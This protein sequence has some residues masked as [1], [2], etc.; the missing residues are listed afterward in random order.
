MRTLILGT[1]YVGKGAQGYGSRM[2]IL[3]AKLAMK[4]NPECDILIVDSASPENP[5][6]FLKPLIDGEGGERLGIYRF[7]DNIGHLNTTGRD[8]WGRALSKGINIAIKEGYDYI[9]YMDVDIIFVR[10]VAEI[11]EK[12]AR[13]GVKV[14]CPMDR[15]YCFLENGLMFMSVPYLRDTKFVER[16]DWA[17]R[18]GPLTDPQTIPEAVFEELMGPDIF[19]LPLRG[20]RDDMGQLTVNNLAG[21]FPYGGADYLTHVKDFAVYERMLEL[22]GI[23]L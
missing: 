16:Y 18:I 6:E 20:M 14:A 9:C 4:L 2:V 23:V 5:C 13:S 10:P 11:I 17:S 15:L 8:G 12:M 1:S 19:T 22:K 21:A 7:D 3:W